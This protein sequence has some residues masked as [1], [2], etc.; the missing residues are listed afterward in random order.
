MEFINQI[1]ES[2]KIWIYQSDRKFSNE[3]NEAILSK[4]ASFVDTWKSHGADVTAYG[5]VL[6]NLFIVL[7]ADDNANSPSGCS[8]DSS[9]NFV[10]KI[11][12]EYQIN[13]FERFN[14]VYNNGDAFEIASKDE[15]VKL[16]QNGTIN[17]DTIVVNNLVTTK[18][19]FANQFEIPL[20]ESWHK[21]FV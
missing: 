8:I 19:D 1:P 7:V 16:Y 18:N 15:F 2:A 11:G 6:H 20:K 9:V 21:N 17:E 14:F 5:T 13:F 12:A 4:V 3:E 10:K